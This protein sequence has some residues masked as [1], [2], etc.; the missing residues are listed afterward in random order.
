VV[1]FRDISEQVAATDKINFLASHDSLTGL[2]NRYAFEQKLNYVLQTVKFKAIQHVICYMDLDQFKVINDT[3]GHLAGDE[4]LKM[5]AHLIKENISEN[6]TLSR[7]GGDEF[8]L[9]L[10]QYSIEKAAELTQKICDSVKEFH[11]VWEDKRFNVGVSIGLAAITRETAS[12][13][14]IMSAIDT[15]CH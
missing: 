6:D 13:Q 7:L 5:V 2:L 15:E 9:I 14:S 1:V 11:F 10:E 12:A 8:G 4:M 3:C